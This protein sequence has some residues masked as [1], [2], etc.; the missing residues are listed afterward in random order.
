V[1][2]AILFENLV[3][4][5]QQKDIFPKGHHLLLDRL[6]EDARAKGHERCQGHRRGRA[7][8]VEFDNV[9]VVVVIPSLDRGAE[10][11]ALK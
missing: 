9:Q 4:D 2:L 1:K 7:G 10:A 3:G 11:F 6:P 8:V 5:L